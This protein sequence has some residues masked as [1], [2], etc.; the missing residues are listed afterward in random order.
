FRRVLFRSIF[1]QTTTDYHLLRGLVPLTFPPGDASGV[2]AAINGVESALADIT[3][4]RAFIDG[5]ANLLGLD[6]NFL[7][8]VQGATLPNGFYNEAFD[9]LFGLLKGANQPVS[10]AIA[11]LQAAT[12]EYNTFRAS[13]DHVVQSLGDINDTYAERF[14]QIT[15]Y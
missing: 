8:L 11:K 6:P 13:V 3:G 15:R 10:D 9:V 5:T 1:G 7:L 4:V 2:N 12:V 14:V